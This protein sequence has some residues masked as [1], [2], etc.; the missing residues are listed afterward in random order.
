VTTDALADLEIAAGAALA[1]G[2]A[3]GAYYG[4]DDLGVR[5]KS[6]GGDAVAPSVYGSSIR[7]TAPRS[8]S[9]ATESSA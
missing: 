9:H 2:R 4:S 8:S 7:W 5:D 1:G 3:A 6:A